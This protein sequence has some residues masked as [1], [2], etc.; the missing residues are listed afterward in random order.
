MINVINCDYELLKHLQDILT[1]LTASTCHPFL[2]TF[3]WKEKIEK[4]IIFVIDSSL[5]A[6]FGSLGV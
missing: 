5:I 3:H 1:V 6:Q 4:G 2:P